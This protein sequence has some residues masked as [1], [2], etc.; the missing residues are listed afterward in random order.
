MAY[1]FARD[2]TVQNSVHSM[3]PATSKYNTKTIQRRSS[4][5]LPIVF[6]TLECVN[7][8]WYGFRAKSVRGCQARRMA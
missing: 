8:R 4:A 6:I 5:E 2:R 1:Q 3:L 7:E